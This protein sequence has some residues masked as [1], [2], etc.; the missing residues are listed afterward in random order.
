MCGASSVTSSSGYARPRRASRSP[1]RRRSRTRRPSSKATTCRR[2]PRRRAAR[3][4]A[5]WGRSRASCGAGRYGESPQRR[6]D[7]RRR[8]RRPRGRSSASG[9]RIDREARVGVAL[10]LVDVDRHGGDAVGLQSAGPR[11]RLARTVGGE[12]EVRG[13]QDGER[14]R[15]AWP[16][17]ARATRASARARRRS[18][19]PRRAAAVDTGIACGRPAPLVAS[20]HT[21]PAGQSGRAA[22]GIARDSSLHHMTASGLILAAAGGGSSGFGGGGGGGGGFSGGGAEAAAASTSA[23]GRA[24]LDRL[25]VP[26]D[27][28]RVRPLRDRQHV[29]RPSA[30][31]A[32]AWTSATRGAHWRR[33]GRAGR[34][35]VRRRGVEADVTR[36]V[37][38]DPGRL[39]R[40][41][42]TA[43]G[44]LVGNDLLVEWRRRL[45]TSPAR[46]GTTACA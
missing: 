19:R 34:R 12:R 46:A 35:G 1:L 22:S 14:A 43:L 42:E 15:R 11:S 8:A 10:D 7:R 37:P 39:G 38:R 20:T 27:L 28:P 2:G 13:R 21:V 18:G 25:R 41:D 44:T 5:R 29:A 9:R 3:R 17:G 40:G 16:A 31:C 24:R 6:V 33:R 32:G 26:R 36:H 4:V 30:A 45:A 23:A